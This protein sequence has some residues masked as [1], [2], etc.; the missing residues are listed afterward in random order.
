MHSFIKFVIAL[1]LLD[2]EAIY[3]GHKYISGTYLH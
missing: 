1:V 3:C 2:K